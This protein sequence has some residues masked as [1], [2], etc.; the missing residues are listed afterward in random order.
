MAKGFRV[1]DVYLQGW[2]G[3]DTAER[4]RVAIR[5][6][7]DVGWVRPSSVRVGGRGGAPSEAYM[8]NPA[9]YAD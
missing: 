8:V 6:L 5:V 7:V 3:L 4:A 2:P 9:V 1:C